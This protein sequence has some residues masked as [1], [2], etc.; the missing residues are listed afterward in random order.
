MGIRDWPEAQRPREKLLRYGV[1]SLTDAELLAIFLRTG[2]KGLDAVQLSQQL[3]EEFG[4]LGPLLGADQDTFC[5]QLGLGQA[6]YVQLQAVLEMAKRHH[7]EC[8]KQDSVFSSSHLVKEYVRQQI[9][10][11]QREVFACLFLDNRHRLLAFEE[12][13]YGTLTEASV[14]PRE[15]VK[16]AL[17]HN[18]AAVILAHNHPSS[19]SIEPSAADR[20]LTHRL[21][22]ALDLVDVRVLDHMIVGDRDVG[23]FAES[24]FM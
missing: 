21:V 9:K 2:I 23:S 24:G 1:R 17:K 4:G 19:G 6:K 10:G 13:F 15:V 22:K 12:L 7:Q 3:L 5:S 16:A 18:A 8:L 11:H 20:L 14:H